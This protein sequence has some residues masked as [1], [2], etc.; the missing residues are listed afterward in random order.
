[1]T[2]R[3]LNLCVADNRGYRALMGRML[4]RVAGIWLVCAVGVLVGGSS[5]WAS[6]IA[7]IGGI[8]D[9]AS[10]GALELSILANE[11]E[12]GVA[13][14]TATAL[15]DDEVVDELVFED[16]TCVDIA[17]PVTVTLT[18]PTAGRPDGNHLL[19]I[20]IENEDGDVFEFERSFEVDNT[21]PVSTPVVTVSVGSNAVLPGPPVGG[22][23]TPQPS[24]DSGCAAPRLSM[25]LA[26][27]PLRYRRG[28]PVLAAGRR[29]RYLGQLTCRIDGRRRVAPRGTLVQFRI[30]IGNRTIVQEPLKVRKDRRLLLKVAYPSSRVLIF[31]VRGSDGDVVTARIPIHV[32]KV[33]R[34]RR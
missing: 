3:E 20:L 14:A 24:G 4:G 25:Y 9:P 8:Q 2:L 31:R 13:L 5:A 6:P 29:Y 12:S 26:Q 10:E 28:V 30:R 11:T 27:D 19:T 22:D 23:E 33:K 34:G 7:A 17:C 16:G 32:V 21:P 18:V 15:L 1:M